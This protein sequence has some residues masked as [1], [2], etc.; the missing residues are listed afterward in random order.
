MTRLNW[1]TR[2]AGRAGFSTEPPLLGGA[3]V[4]RA[5]LTLLLLAGVTSAQSAAPTHRSILTPDGSRFLLVPTD[6]P[7]VVHWVVCTPAGPLEDPVGLEGLAHATARTALAGPAGIGCRDIE[8]EKAALDRLDKVEVEVARLQLAGAPIPSEL[9]EQLDAARSDARSISDPSA[10]ELEIRRAPA[11]ASELVES[12]EASLWHLTIALEGLPRV[13]QLIMLSREDAVLRGVHE[14]FRHVREEARDR[15]QSTRF[16]PAREEVLAQHYLGIGHPYGRA[17]AALTQP[18]QTLTRTQ[19]LATYRQSHHPTRT[20]HVLSGGFSLPAVESMLQ[21][22]FAKTTLREPQKLNMPGLR[23]LEIERRSLLPKARDAGAVLAW[24]MPQDTRAETLEGL[25]DWLVEGQD[26]FLARGLRKQG[27]PALNVSGVPAFPGRRG[28]GLVLFEIGPDP[29]SERAPLPIEPVLTGVRELLDTAA[30][31]GP[32][33][34]DL[35]RVVSSLRARRGGTM[36]SP[37]GLTLELAL[38]CGIYGEAPAQAL[39]PTPPSAEELRAVLR[40]MLSKSRPVVVLME[41]GK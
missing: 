25:V 14:E 2:S 16:A 18:P 32:S 8:R 13:A 26:S 31:E 3:R 33:L 1:Q 29:D 21:R 20:F 38:R 6:G 17:Y 28:E 7:P 37:R 23:D 11:L 4:S 12:E 15:L 36:A 34:D 10:F 19:A 27:Q 39:A 35:V 41:S 24:R 40:A 5:T 30:K 22:A 9:G